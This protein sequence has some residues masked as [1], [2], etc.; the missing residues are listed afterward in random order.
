MRNRLASLKGYAM[1][2]YVMNSFDGMYTHAL[3]KLWQSNFR[4]DTI[5]HACSNRKCIILRAIFT[6]SQ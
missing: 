3:Q 4:E 2:C 1:L 6:R 5:A